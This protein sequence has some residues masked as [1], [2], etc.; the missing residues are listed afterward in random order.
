HR[1]E[2]A[3]RDEM[4]D[5]FG[6]R[7][8]LEDCA[9]LD[10]VALQMVRVRDVAVVRDREAAARKIG[11]ERLDVTQAGAAGGRIAHVADGHLALELGKRFGG[12]K[13][14]RHMAESAARE[15]LGAVE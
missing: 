1:L 15:E 14:L 5:D 12:G 8:R 13:V 7:G 4:D 2:A 11:E 6:V 9:S 3:C 10:E